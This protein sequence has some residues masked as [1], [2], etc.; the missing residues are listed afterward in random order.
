MTVYSRLLPRR[1]DAIFAGVMVGVSQ[2]EVWAY[3][4]AGGSWQ[5]AATLGLAAA[6]MVYRGRYPVLS[7][8]MVALGLMLCAQYA[9]QPFSVTSVVTF[10]TGMFSVGAMPQRRVSLTA[11]VVALVVSAFAVQPWTL[12]N[13]LGISLSS[14]GVPWLLGAL[15]LRRHASREEAHRHRHAAEEAVAAERIRLAQD[16]HDVVSHTVGMIVVQAGAADVTLDKDPEATRESLHAIETGARDTLLE[17]RRM[18]GL[19]RDDDPD[20]RASRAAVSDLPALFAPLGRAGVEVTMEATG[21]PTLLT[22][23][24]EMTIFRI[25]QEALTNVVKHAGP[26]RVTVSLRYTPRALLVEVADDGRTTTPPGPGRGYGLSG[27]RER[28]TALGGSVTAGPR[29]G[30]GFVVDALLPL[31]TP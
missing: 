8:A 2:V 11:L 6:A 31:A 28:V 24:V 21:Q 25:V 10:L 13:Y 3:G 5:A 22:P 7:V 23:E 30:G 4:V 9:G 27:I 16:L 14:I 1:D 12:N 26:C 18:L 20:P 17:L 19:L 29:P 15:W